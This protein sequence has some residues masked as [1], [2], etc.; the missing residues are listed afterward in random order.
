MRHVHE[1]EKYHLA[2]PIIQT[3]VIEAHGTFGA[4]VIY[5]NLSRAGVICLYSPAAAKERSQGHLSRQHW[6]AHGVKKHACQYACDIL[7]AKEQ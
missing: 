2:L 4:H 7:G 6:L 3:C 1:V 5:R